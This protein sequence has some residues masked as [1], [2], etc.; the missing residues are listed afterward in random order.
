[1]SVSGHKSEAS[2][3][4]YA[5]IVGEDHKYQMSHQIATTTGSSVDND[6]GIQPSNHSG[7]LNL[8]LTEDREAG[9]EVIGTFDLG[10]DN[11]LH[12]I[13]G[14][15]NTSDLNKPLDPLVENHTH[16]LSV[17]RKVPDQL[18]ENCEPNL[19]P[20]PAPPVEKTASTGTFNIKDCVVNIHYH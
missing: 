18:Q 8:S 17:C 14:T 6:I 16:N 9:I 20:Q 4:E 13:L 15:I 10:L 2:I 3:R 1:M 11:V 12:D 5:S 7:N 19:N